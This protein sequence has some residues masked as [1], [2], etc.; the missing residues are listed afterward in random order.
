MNEML[1]NLREDIN[2]DIKRQEE[3]IAESLEERIAKILEE[4]MLLLEQ[5]INARNDSQYKLQWQQ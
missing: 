1:K 5:R 3:R 2:N 4:R